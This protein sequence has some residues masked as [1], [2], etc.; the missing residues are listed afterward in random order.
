MKM[1]KEEYAK[2]V[3][4]MSPS[5]PASG[6][7]AK[8]FVIGGL[9]CCV[10]QTVMNAYRLLGAREDLASA[11]TTVTMIFLGSLLTGLRVYDKLAKHAGAGTLVPVTGFANSVTSP[12]MEFHSE[13][14]VT[15]TCTKM[16]VIAGPVIVFG[17]TASSI[18]GLIYWLATSVFR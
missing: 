5:Q 6:K 12:A 3:K 18:Y 9:I 11:A 4:K 16:F 1:S 14:V 2:Y 13:G 10:G 8:A 17:I 7:L 15:G